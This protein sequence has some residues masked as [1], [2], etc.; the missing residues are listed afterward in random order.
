MLKY[1]KHLVKTNLTGHFV[2]MHK[3]GGRS[4][5]VGMPLVMRMPNEDIP[6]FEEVIVEEIDEKNVKIEGVWQP[7]RF[8]R[9]GWSH[10]FASTQGETIDENYCIWDVRH[11]ITSVAEI[12]TAAPR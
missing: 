4:W 2:N 10:T 12:V 3:L 9:L 7:K 8:F 11:P 1:S 6:T 5:Y